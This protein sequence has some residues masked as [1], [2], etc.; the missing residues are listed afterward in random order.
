[1]K[2]LKCS[3]LGKKK[4]LLLV[5]PIEEISLSPELFSPS[6]FQN[7]VGGGYRERYERSKDGQKLLGL[8]IG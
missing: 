7:P 8:N 5:L 3:L 1:M 4:N 6:P 2:I